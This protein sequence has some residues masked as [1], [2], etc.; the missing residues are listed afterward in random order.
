MAGLV[1]A[2]ELFKGRHIDREVVVSCL[3]WYLHFWLMYLDPA[4]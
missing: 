4:G 1:S 3:R 2:D